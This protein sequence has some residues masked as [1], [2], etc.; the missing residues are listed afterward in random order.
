MTMKKIDIAA[1]QRL[2]RGKVLY[3]DLRQTSS[4]HTARATLLWQLGGVK[5]VYLLSFSAEYQMVLPDEKIIADELKRSRVRLE[6]R[7][8]KR[9]QSEEPDS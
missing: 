4:E 3:S 7:R 9:I 1:T 5:L 2:A 6:E 8:M